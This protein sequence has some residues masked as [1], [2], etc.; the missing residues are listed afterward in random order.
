MRLVSAIREE[1]PADAFAWAATI[2]EGPLRQES[3]QE[4]LRH[5]G[6]KD[7]AAA[8]AAID[9]LPREEQAAARAV[10]EKARASSK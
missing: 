3:V 1:D 6:R 5:W 8:T 4:T 7:P 2:Q 9:A 10:V